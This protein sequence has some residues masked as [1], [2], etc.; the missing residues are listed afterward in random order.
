MGFG[1]VNPLSRDE[2]AATERWLVIMQVVDD[3]VADFLGK[4]HDY[5]FRE[6]KIEERRSIKIYPWKNSVVHSAIDPG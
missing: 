6:W 5:D 4:P 3:E 2:I 1:S